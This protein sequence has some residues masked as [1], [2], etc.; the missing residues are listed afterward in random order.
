MLRVDALLVA[1]P[2][3]SGLLQ[4][5][6]S[7]ARFSCAAP[8]NVW[9]F[10]RERC[11]R[12]SAS[13]CRISWHRFFRSLCYR[14]IP[15]PTHPLLGG[16]TAS[17]NLIRPPV[18]S[19]LLGLVC[20]GIVIFGGGKIREISKDMH[21]YGQL[22]DVAGARPVVLRL[23]S[24]RSRPRPRNSSAFVPRRRTLLLQFHLH[25]ARLDAGNIRCHSRE[26]P[27]YLFP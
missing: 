19:R 18:V 11:T 21:S 16:T 1:R 13:A 5:H 24:Q 4:D 6:A 15:R 14:A 20:S 27:A 8:V 9:R 7:D 26:R 22:V 25:H 12:G 23:Y 10:L 3:C 17:S 2:P